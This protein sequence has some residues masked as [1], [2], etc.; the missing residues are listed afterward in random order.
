V[1][2]EGHAHQPFQESPDTWNAIVDRF[3][4]RL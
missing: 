3:W 2:L 1:L 4:S